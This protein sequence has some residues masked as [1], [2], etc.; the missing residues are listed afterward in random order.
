M[1]H[2][3]P[4]LLPGRGQKAGHTGYSWAFPEMAF[5]SWFQNVLFSSVGYANPF[6]S[7][8]SAY[9]SGVT[10]PAAAFQSVSLI[11]LGQATWLALFHRL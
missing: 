1:A 8:I 2:V 7:R 9:P 11:E 4:K 10:G 6:N 3:S 5:L